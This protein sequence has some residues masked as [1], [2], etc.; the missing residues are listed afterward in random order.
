[1]YNQVMRKFDDM[2]KFIWIE[3]F[4]W[5]LIICFCAF[6]IRIYRY[7]KVKHLAT[8]QIFL[9]DV[10]GLIVGSPVK[11]L[12]VQIGYIKKIKIITDEVYIKFVITDKNIKLPKGAIA[13]VEFTGMGG[14]KSL[15]IYPPTSETIAS[16]K[17]I[18]TSDPV[19]LSDSMS[20]LNDMFGKIN[21][22]I[23]RT[24]YFA[25]ETGVLGNGIDTKGIEK[26]I[27]EAD[28]LIKKVKKDE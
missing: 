16:G 4:I 11:F 3:L 1:M 26:N 28:K 18:T 13:T 5:F 10:D 22:I 20:L 25:K 17:I 24:S 8:Y 23:V 15:E 6:G 21:S 12:G 14:S 7:N 9:P 19:R 27:N 2:H